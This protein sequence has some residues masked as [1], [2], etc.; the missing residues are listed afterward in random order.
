MTFQPGN[1][2]AKK[3]PTIELQLEAY[4]QYCNWI[5][6]GYPKKSWGFDHP[7]ITLTWETMEKYIREDPTVFDP[8]QKKRA[9][10]RS[11]EGWFDVLAGIAK[12]DNQ[13]GN[14][15]ACQMIFRNMFKWDTKEQREEEDD[16][17]ALQANEKLMGQLSQLQKKED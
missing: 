6:K 11:F 10:T 14:V 1:Q 5:A 9:E 12:G 4:R 13:K 16:G 15:A 3:L 2:I 8:L 7:T 17:A